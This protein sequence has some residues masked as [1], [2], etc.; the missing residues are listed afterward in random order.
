MMEDWKETDLGLIPSDWNEGVLSKYAEKPQYGFTDSSSNNGNVKFLRITDITDIGVNWNDVPFCNCHDIDKY[1]LKNGDIVF[2]RIGATTGKSYIIKNPPLAVFA[3]YLIRVRTKNDLLSDY[4]IYY[5][6]S[7]YY[8][9][10]INCQKGTNLKGGVNGSI[11]STLKIILPSLPEQHKIAYILSTVQ[12]AIEQQ[13][14]LICTTTELKKAL[15]QKLFTEGTKGEKQ[16]QTEIGLA[17]ESWEVV[18]LSYVCE[19]PQYGFTDSASTQGNA[20]FLRITDITEFGVNWNDVPFC[21]CPD[22]EKYE[23]KDG[24]IVFARIGATTGKSYLISNPPKSVY[25]SYLIRVRCKDEILPG[26]LIYYFVSDQY[27]K[28]ID[29]TKGNNLKGGV[30]GSILSKLLTPKPS[31]KEQKSISD[32]F[33]VLD[34][35]LAFCIKKKQTLTDLFKTLLHELMTG[36]RRVHEIDFDTQ[37]QEAAHA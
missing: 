12:K 25:A 14:K 8:W 1:K 27:W 37:I 17:P 22:F 19:K 31:I 34:N 30:N 29:T 9:R 33:K 32:M 13:D 24:D 4:L 5:F 7:E 15:M 10:Q 20:K 26:F 36:Q 21:N 11:L 2:A 35:K 18:E 28:Q 23:L 6:S 16:K 3:S